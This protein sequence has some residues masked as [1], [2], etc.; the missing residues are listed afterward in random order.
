MKLDSQVRVLIVT[1]KP[2]DR[3][4][5]FVKRKLHTFNIGVLM[6]R[7]PWAESIQNASARGLIYPLLK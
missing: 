2:Y 1:A 7:R 5:E 4:E 6:R 3:S